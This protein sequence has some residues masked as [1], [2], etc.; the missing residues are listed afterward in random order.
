MSW[1]TARVGWAVARAAY[2]DGGAQIVMARAWGA[3]DERPRFVVLHSLRTG[4]S[5]TGA[6]RNVTEVAKGQDTS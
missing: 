3:G 5:E 1:T 4:Y 2:G 6:D